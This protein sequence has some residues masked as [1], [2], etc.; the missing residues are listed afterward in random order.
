M[1][2]AAGPGGAAD[3]STATARRRSTAPQVGRM[4]AGTPEP[5]PRLDS[6]LRGL[7][8]RVG[9]APVSPFVPGAAIADTPGPRPAASLDSAR[10][11]D[12][13][14]SQT[15][16]GAGTAISGTD[17]AITG[18]G[19]AIAARSERAYAA[20]LSP[21]AAA[22]LELPAAA[23]APS[24]VETVAHAEF[25]T[26]EPTPEPEQIPAAIPAPT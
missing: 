12:T 11:V 19:T 9:A 21:A 3:E 25:S 22:E 6:A 5:A 8:R 17:S 14:P 18:T 16:G 2:A 26:L 13:D 4:V 1:S 20:D 23:E 15:A 10:T 24:D 7:A